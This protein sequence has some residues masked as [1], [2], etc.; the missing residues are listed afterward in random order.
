[1]NVGQFMVLFERMHSL[2]GMV[3]VLEGFY[4]E[5]EAM[6]LLADRIVDY[7]IAKLNRLGE[8]FGDR[9]QANGR[10]P[11]VG[12]SSATTGTGRR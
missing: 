12:S 4:L 11:T 5:P 7:D 9:I 1:M 10:F 3:K 2:M 8:A 6:G